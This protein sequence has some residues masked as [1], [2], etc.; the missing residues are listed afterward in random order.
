MLKLFKGEVEAIG[1]TIN[2]SQPFAFVFKVRSVLEQNKNAIERISTKK[3]M[4]R[5]RYS[6]QD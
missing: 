1:V 5:I 6:L 3:A 2:G 4:K